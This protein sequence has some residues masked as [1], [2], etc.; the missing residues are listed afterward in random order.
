MSNETTNIIEKKGT[1]MA[2]QEKVYDPSMNTTDEFINGE[3]NEYY[4]P[5]R[6]MYIHNMSNRSTLA[7]RGSIDYGD[8]LGELQLREL[9]NRVKEQNKNNRSYHKKYGRGGVLCKVGIKKRKYHID[10]YLYEEQ[11]DVSKYCPTLYVV[12]KKVQNMIANS[13]FYLRRASD[14]LDAA[15]SE[16][17]FNDE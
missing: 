8:K 4:V 1:N 12:G 11:I 13:N 15:E 7:Y 2:T 14:L 10:V 9:R 5:Q 16:G 17:A 6:G 3:Y